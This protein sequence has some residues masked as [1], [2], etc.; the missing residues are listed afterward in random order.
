MVRKLLRP[1]ERHWRV[2]GLCGIAILFGVLFFAITFYQFFFLH[3]QFPGHHLAGF[4]D[5]FFYYVQ[6][7]RNIVHVGNLTFDNIS[8]TNG[9]QP[10]WLAFLTLVGEIF[11]PGEMAFFVVVEVA[12]ATLC[13]YGTY[14]FWE[15]L[16]FLATRDDLRPAIVLFALIYFLFAFQIARRGMEVALVFALFPQFFGSILALAERPSNRAAFAAGLWSSLL[17][18]SRLD[19]VI[20]ILCLAV[21][22][23]LM[24]IRTVPR[25]KWPALIAVGL[26]GGLPFFVY[27]AI[28][29]WYFGA[30]MPISGAAKG[31]RDHYSIVS[32]AWQS[33]LPPFPIGDPAMSIGG[34]L[35]ILTG[36]AVSLK[37]LPFA[38]IRQQILMTTLAAVPV[39][40]LATAVRSDWPLWEWYLYPIVICMPIAMLVIG[41]SLPNLIV[42]RLPI[43]LAVA[44][45]GVVFVGYAAAKVPQRRPEQNGLL[46]VGQ[47]LAAFAQTHPGR[48]A[49]GDRAGIVGYLLSVPVLQV[50]GLVSDRQ[51]LN[52]I[53]TK[54]DLR[55][56]LRSRSIEYYIATEPRMEGG[57]WQVA[58]PNN[59]G[60]SA[61]RMRGSFCETPVLEFTQDGIVTGI[62][63]P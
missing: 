17:L 19:S 50:E 55:Q 35:L 25:R 12:T 40:Y 59:A 61:P 47:K 20:I 18:L 16:N 21:P 62:F 44:V 22:L 15:L 7:V 28:N 3:R 11:D 33:F 4:A 36:L 23:A 56:F 8:T 52:A 63:R 29:Q 46:V 32:R 10:L 14:R 54:A 41:E 38:S 5:D 49:M 60:P 24:T 51:T 6:I 27:L 37:R 30:L 45:V 57:C 2:S 43:N 31:L 34:A 42:G 26:A 1:G 53:R 13:A 48:Y 9:Y 39:Y 58:E